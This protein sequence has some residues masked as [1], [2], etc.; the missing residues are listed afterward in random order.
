MFLGHLQGD[1][2]KFR[3]RLCE[4]DPGFEASNNEQIVCVPSF[5]PRAT[6]LDLLRHHYGHPKLG[7]VC[8]LGTDKT[9]GSHT[10]DR[11]RPIINKKGASDRSG[12]AAEA[13]VP[14][15]I[16]EDDDRM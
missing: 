13:F 7:S 11:E 1:G 15:R 5:E 10:D 12:I 9:F 3:L 16:A 4:R 14:A 8:H 6:W 2:F